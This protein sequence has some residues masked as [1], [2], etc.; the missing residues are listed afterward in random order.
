VSQGGPHREQ[1]ADAHVPNATDPRAAVR[2]RSREPDQPERPAAASHGFSLAP[3]AAVG[4]LHLELLRLAT[5]RSPALVIWLP[6]LVGAAVLVGG[7]LARGVLVL[8]LKVQQLLAVA[9][10]AATV[11]AA[12]GRRRRV[13]RG[14]VPAASEGGGRQV[15]P[16]WLAARRAEQ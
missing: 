15:G 10:A 4:V 14:L 16:R 13:V 8:P 1:G 12:A 9:A 3:G 2:D 11:L 5:A 7:L 6:L